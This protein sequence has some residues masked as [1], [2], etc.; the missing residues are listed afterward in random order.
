[1]CL[2]P[3]NMLNVKGSSEMAFFRVWSNQVFESL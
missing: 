2:G 3:F 1:M